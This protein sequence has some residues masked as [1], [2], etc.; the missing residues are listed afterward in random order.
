MAAGDAKIVEAR[1]DEFMVPVC[2]LHH[3]ELHRSGNE[4][5]WWRMLKINPVPVALRLWQQ[6]RADN[7]QAQAANTPDGSH[8][9]G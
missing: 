5:G 9:Q 7:G 1:S 6:S 8:H 3:R 4:L 2:R